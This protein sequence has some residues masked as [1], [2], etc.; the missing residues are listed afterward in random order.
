MMPSEVKATL[1]KYFVDLRVMTLLMCI[2]LGI[3]LLVLTELEVFSRSKFMAFGPRPDLS[4]MHVAIDTYYKYN[5]LIAM[6]VVH[7]FVTDLIADSLVPH[8]LNFVQVR[9]P[10]SWPALCV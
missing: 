1:K 10:C 3:V 2:W 8:V 9:A 7:T 5:I 4:F 6:I